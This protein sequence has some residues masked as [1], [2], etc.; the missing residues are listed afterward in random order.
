MLL[1]KESK[2]KTDDKIARI[3]NKLKSRK[4]LESFKSVAAGTL[5]DYVYSANA[6]NIKFFTTM[7]LI[8]R[9]THNGED[10]YYY[11]LTPNGK[12]VH[13]RLLLAE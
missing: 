2:N 12:E 7:G 11:D 3:I 1:P 4:E 10:D 9:T 6:E 8:K 5:N 13:E